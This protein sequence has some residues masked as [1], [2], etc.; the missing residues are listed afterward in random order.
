MLTQ[1]K[2][3]LDL[4]DEFT[5][6]PATMDD[7]ETA[8]E[9][10]NICSQVQIGADEANV[11]EIR[12]EWQTPGF[13]LEDSVRLVLTPEDQLVG[14]VEVWDL[15]EPPV[16]I[17]IWGRVHPDYEG[18]GIGTALMT[19]A[20]QRARQAVTRAPDGVQ[21]IM[22][23]GT[24]ST[25]QPPKPLFRQIGMEL[26]RHF[27]RMVIDLDKAI[28]QPQLPEGIVIRTFETVNDLRAVY[29]AE[30]DAFRDHWGFVAQSEEEVLE[31]WQHW[32]EN[33]EE[34][35][36]SLWFLAMDGE[37]IAGIALCRP[38]ITDD[39]EMGFVDTL[40][41]RR[42]WRR[43]GVALALLHHSFAEFKRRSQKRV[44]LGV[45]ADSLT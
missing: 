23:T 2:T 21:V 5:M 44:G 6:L 20:E 12:N 25:Y 17:W 35:D 42:P 7:L 1:T 15:A 30:E 24:I 40:G 22:Q 8:V 10:F 39:P 36:P 37:E 41:V 34:F 4:L 27:W 19:W 43:Q 9:L 13:S 31:R 33:D 38:K 45:D 32:I 29:R 18:Q 28:P 3:E 16:R 11:E 26:K 14:Y